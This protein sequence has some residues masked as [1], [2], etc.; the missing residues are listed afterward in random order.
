MD[1]ALSSTEGRTS[2]VEPTE[3]IVRLFTITLVSILLL[4]SGCMY[5][6]KLN[7][8]FFQANG[9]ANK[10]PLKAYVVFDRTLDDSSYL[11]DDIFFGHGVNIKTKPGLK[12]AINSALVSTFDTVYT[13]EKIE[14]VIVNSYD[15]VVIPRVEF[16]DKIMIISVAVKEA[17]SGKPIETYKRSGNIR[18]TAPAFAQVL[19]TLNIIPGSLLTT[20]IIAPIITEII[21]AQAQK[22]LESVLSSSLLAITDDIRNDRSL[23][24]RF[25][26][27]LLGGLPIDQPLVR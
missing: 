6:G 8:D 25:K 16:L 7:Q 10:L 13:G 1:G 4:C 20:P 12:T 15:I 17:V 14:F 11:E 18:I 23:M 22:D 19:A 3:G 9:N 2:H 27:E 26:P 24:M 21:G 5:N